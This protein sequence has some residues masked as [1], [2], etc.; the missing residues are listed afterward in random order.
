[1]RSS[2][3]LVEI[4]TEEIPA[5]MLEDAIRQFAGLVTESLRS[6]RLE[7]G[8]STTWY[9]P[10]RLILWLRAIPQKQPDLVET[11]IGPPKRVGYDASGAPTKAA[12]AFAEKNGVPVTA[13]R[14]SETSRGEYLTAVRTV[15][16]EA[17]HK[18]LERFIPESIGRIQFPKTMY[19]TSDKFRFAR[20]VRWILALFGNRILR[21]ALADVRSDRFT[22]GHR[23]LG[24]AR[25]KVSSPGSLKALLRKNGVFIDPDERRLRIQKGLASLARKVQAN[26]VEDPSLLDTVVNLNEYP[27]VIRGSFDPEFLRLPEEILVTVMREHQKYFSLRDARGNLLP[28]FLAAINLDRDRNREIT[29]GHERVLRARLADAAFFWETDRKVPL[30]NR[31]AALKQVLFQEK[32][33]T[34]HDKVARISKLIRNL[35]AAANATTLEEDLRKAARLMKCDLVTE[36]VKEFP[37]LQGIVGGLYARAEGHPENVWRAIYDHY[38]PKSTNSSSPGTI[39]GAI[40]ALADKLDTVCGCFSA[41]LIPKGSSDPFGVRRLG[42][43]ILKIILDH[44]LR[45]RLGTLIQ[46]GSGQFPS[47]SEKIREELQKFLEGR[48]RFLFQEMGFAYDCINATLATGFTGFDD[49]VDTLARVRALQSM[50]SDPDFLAVATNFKRIKNILAQA[51]AT[52]YGSPESSLMSES[53]EKDLLGKYEETK[54]RVDQACN[55]QD[56]ATAL[57]AM[58]SMRPAVDRFFD[59]VLVMEPDP[60]IRSNRLNLL[61]AFDALFRRVADISEMVIERSS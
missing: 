53:A 20:P 26:L 3:L 40:L 30:E 4:G 45:V 19:W 22:A 25:I 55:A 52:S 16:G 6:N 50:R 46:W 32:L 7:F 27:S 11:V 39:A 44:S 31:V 54:P 5:W 43:G 23:Y 33:G 37:D 56:Y 9:T 47:D 15:G 8:E 13:L 42:N 24:K 58:A 38:L 41:G 35:A 51:G 48:L 12:L 59:K 34:Y 10:R 18:L 61:Y 28:H 21:F 17:T 1:M 49:V 60:G 2:D 36:M 57:R 14:L 29:K